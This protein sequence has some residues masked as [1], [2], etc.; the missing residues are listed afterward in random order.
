MDLLHWRHESIIPIINLSSSG[1]CLSFPYRSQHLIFQILMKNQPARF[2]KCYCSIRKIWC[3][4][5]LSLKSA[6]LLEEFQNMSHKC[7]ICLFIAAVFI[8]VCHIQFYSFA[9]C[10]SL[11]C[12]L[13]GS[14]VCSCD[15]DPNELTDKPHQTS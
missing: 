1:L 7:I 10:S 2:L 3:L 13:V 12:S 15:L 5:F 6:L 14:C 11:F 8:K 4:S 9:A